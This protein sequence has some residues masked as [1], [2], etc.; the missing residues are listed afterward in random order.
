MQQIEM[1]QEAFLVLFESEAE[2]LTDYSIGFV[3]PHL[4]GNIEDGRLGGSGSLVSI[5]GVEGILTAE[6]VVRDLQKRTSAGIILSG[7]PKGDVHRFV[8]KPA[9]CRDFSYHARPDHPADGPD[10]SFLVLPPDTTAALRA[11]KS[12][13][14]L[15][16]RRTAMLE[17]PPSREIGVWAI[18]GIAEEW[19][20]DAPSQMGFGRIK[21][22]NGRLL[23]PLERIAW[24]TSGDFDYINFE[25]VYDDGYGGPQSFGGYS[26]GGIWQLIIKPIE[27]LPTVVDRHL[28]G[29]AFYQ[30]DKTMRG[31]E[32][33]REVFSHGRESIYRMLLSHV[34]ECMA[35]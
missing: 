16:K 20:I 10:L 21:V 2:R 5:D 9:L 6:H 14:N 25:V 8:F 4:E 24:R 32:A 18:C 22:F 19:T 29:V 35:Q 28:M 7:Y 27:G 34:R 3:V 11:R 23:G 31:A 17:D 12:F 33:I 1:D 30:S 15:S 26:G 13:Y